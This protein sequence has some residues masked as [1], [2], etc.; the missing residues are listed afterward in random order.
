TGIYVI[1]VYLFTVVLLLWLGRHKIVW[2][3]I[4]YSWKYRLAFIILILVSLAGTALLWRLL[5]G[6]VIRAATNRLNISELKRTPG[7]SV[8][9]GFFAA[10]W[11]RF[12]AM[13][14]QTIAP[15]WAWKIFFTLFLVGHYYCWRQRRIWIPVLYWLC[16]A[17]AHLALF[18]IP[19]D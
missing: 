10:T 19:I 4:R 11:R 8:S 12:P 7:V 14:G 6:Q 18:L 9:W 5:G 3:H 16:Y 2:H 1:T 15:V 13:S 17:L